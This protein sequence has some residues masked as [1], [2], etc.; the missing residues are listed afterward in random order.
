MKVN[1]SGGSIPNAVKSSPLFTTKQL[2]TDVRLL[3][4]LRRDPP[5]SKFSGNPLTL[6]SGGSG[7]TLMWENCMEP[8]WWVGMQEGVYTRQDSR[9]IS[10]EEI[11]AA[12]ARAGID[13]DLATLALAHRPAEVAE[14][15]SEA[16]AAYAKWKDSEDAKSD[17]RKADTRAT[18]VARFPMLADPAVAQAAVD[19]MN[20]LLK[21]H[22]RIVSMS[23][24]G[25]LKDADGRGVANFKSIDGMRAWLFQRGHRASVDDRHLF[26]ADLLGHESG[27]NSSPR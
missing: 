3:N 8:D 22:P 14:R 21:L 16:A 5:L 15:D 17:A 9:L 12:A 4:E 24:K 25:H 7:L 23:R 18:L 10:D 13:V 6:T 1:L 27:E 20:A 19:E 11:L 2:L 26:M